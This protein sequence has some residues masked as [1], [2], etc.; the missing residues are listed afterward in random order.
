MVE[1]SGE[2]A[3][4]NFEE[5]DQETAEAVRRARESV[6][7]FIAQLPTLREQG[8]HFSVKVPIAT[9][10]GTEHVWLDSA[11]FGDGTFVGKLGK[12]PLVEPLKLGDTVL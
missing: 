8:A 1:R 11:K 7:R 10:A 5:N 6:D 9:G 12:V 4:V 3:V 2:P